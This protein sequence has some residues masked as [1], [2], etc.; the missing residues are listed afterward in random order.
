MGFTAAYALVHVRCAACGEHVSKILIAHLNN[1]VISLGVH[2]KES[3]M[4]EMQV[5]AW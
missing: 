3:H 4:L 5:R 1:L 2:R